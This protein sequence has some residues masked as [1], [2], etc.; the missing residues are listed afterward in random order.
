M[1][2][3]RDPGNWVAPA[4]CWAEETLQAAG[5]PAKPGYY[6]PGSDGG[7]VPARCKLM[8]EEVD[9]V[10][11]AGGCCVNTLI[12]TL[13]ICGGVP[14]VA[15]LVDALERTDHAAESPEVAAAETLT[16]LMQVGEAI[17]TGKP[18]A[19]AAAA[20]WVGRLH[21]RHQPASPRV[22]RGGRKAAIE[23]A[24][25]DE[26]VQI[27]LLARKLHD[28]NPGLRPTARAREIARHLLEQRLAR[29]FPALGAAARAR[30]LSDNLQRES[31]RV[32]KYLQRNL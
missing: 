28:E 1:L 30:F 26:H 6:T 22:R 7:L 21:E 9:E 29:D 2:L 3:G 32:R 20:Y 10:L 14:W 19:A 23:R 12:E 24:D 31:G 5:L 27:L 17:R 4:R 25:D 16:Q 13:G 18:E 8:P 15:S 11:A